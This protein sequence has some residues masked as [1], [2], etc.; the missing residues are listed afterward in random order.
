MSLDSNGNA[1]IASGG[2]GVYLVSPDGTVVKESPFTGGGINGPWSVTVDGDDNVWV[3][4][5]GSM[6]PGSVYGNEGTNAAEVVKAAISKLAGANTAEPGKAISPANGYTL[7]SAG[8]PVLLNNQPLYGARGPAEC[9]SPL[10]RQTNL[11]IDQAGNV[12]ALNNWKPDF[13]VDTLSD[14]ATPPNPA[15]PGGDG[16]VIFVGLAKPPAKKH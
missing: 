7:P 13:D 12:W 3:A 4:N 16:V 6:N 5:F 1:W 14:N 2:E 15:N 9:F 8:D 11:L 10:M